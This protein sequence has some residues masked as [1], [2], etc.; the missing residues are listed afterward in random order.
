[1]TLTDAHCHYHDARLAPYLAEALSAART[2]GLAGAV[3]NGTAET[4]WDAV[5]GFCG[6]H[7]WALPAFGIHPW[8]TAGR[9]QNWERN[10]TA[11]LDRHPGASVGEIGLDLWIE[12]RDFEDQRRLFLR[13]LAIAAERNVPASIHCVRAWEP[14]RQCLRAQAAPARG[15][16]LHAYGGPAELLPFFVEKGARFSF[17]PSFLQ[18]RK[19]PLRDAFRLM[20]PDR[21]L[22]ETDSPAL[23]P[24]PERNPRPLRDEATGEP[25][26]HPAN[27]RL[28]LE[29]LAESL[30]LTPEETAALTARNWHALFTADGGDVVSEG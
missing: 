26:N 23:P 20:P 21:V 8:H 9:S 7:A 1:M 22:L 4:D 17:S 6:E 19:A 11:A 30:G 10:L 13:Q 28:A 15:V 12:P 29:A 2:A 24:P 5:S 27:L 3:V 25:L 18:A 14:L 16:L